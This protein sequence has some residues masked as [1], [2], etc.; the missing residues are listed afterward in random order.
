LSR[1][2]TPF[3]KLSGF[4]KAGAKAQD[5][6]QTLSRNAEALLLS[7]QARKGEIC[8]FFSGSHAVSKALIGSQRLRPD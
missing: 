2:T 5:Q 3:D 1:K 8:G 7:H 6:S 4:F